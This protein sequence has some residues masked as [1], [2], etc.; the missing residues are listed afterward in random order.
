MGST[1]IGSTL[2]RGSVHMKKILL[3]TAMSVGLILGGVTA[4]AS[5]DEATRHK[6]HSVVSTL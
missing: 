1:P 4:C 2:E 5:D 6:T 3:V